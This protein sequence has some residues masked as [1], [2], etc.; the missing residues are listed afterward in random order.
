MTGL[1]AAMNA[2][3]RD[4]RHLARH[5]IL[6]LTAQ[7]LLGMAVDLLG[8]PSQATGAAQTASTVFLAAHVLIAVGLAVGAILVIGATAGLTDQ[9]R[10]LAICGSAAIAATIAAGI[11]TMTTKSNWWSY[12]MALGFIAALLTYGRLLIQAGPRGGIPGGRQSTDSVDSPQRLP[13][14][15]VRSRRQSRPGQRQPSRTQSSQRRGPKL[16]PPHQADTDTLQ[17][18]FS[19]PTPAPW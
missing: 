6:G 13:E 16:T 12:G 15:Q 18:P 8:L 9:S 1:T 7:F 19:P 5:Q 11:L 3:R 17:P 14:R 4:V 2:H 10:R